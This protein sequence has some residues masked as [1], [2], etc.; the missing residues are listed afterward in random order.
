MAADHGGRVRDAGES[1]DDSRRSRLDGS[2]DH[3]RGGA[4][5]FDDFHVVDRFIEIERSEQHNPE[6]KRVY[7]EAKRRFNDFYFALR[8]VFEKHQAE[9]A[10]GWL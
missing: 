8:P 2:S 10:D 5:L 6:N 1:S 4:G 7:E 3:R 9:G